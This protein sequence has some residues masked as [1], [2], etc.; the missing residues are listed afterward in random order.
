MRFAYDGAAA[1]VQGVGG[2]VTLLADGKVMVS[3]H[4]DHTLG[5][6]IS[7]NETMDVGNDYGAPVADYPFPAPFTGAL[8]SVSLDIER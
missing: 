6:L 4:I 8:G 7:P 5:G 1:K 3:S 2:T